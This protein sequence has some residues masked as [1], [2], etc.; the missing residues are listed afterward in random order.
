MAKLVNT[1][2]YLQL[3]I[4]SGTKGRAKTKVTKVASSSP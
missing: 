1:L 2:F 4:I 3:R